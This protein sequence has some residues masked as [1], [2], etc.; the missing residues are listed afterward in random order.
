MVA[1]ATIGFSFAI[2]GSGCSKGFQ[3]DPYSSESDAVKHRIA[4]TKDVQVPVGKADPSGSLRIDSD[5]NMEFS[6]GLPGTWHIGGRILTQVDGHDPV[7]G[8]D[9]EISIDNIADF[10]FANFDA[11]TGTL[12]W[13]PKPGFV[14]DHFTRNVHFDISLVT[15]FAPIRKT[16]KSLLAV[17]T[18]S[19]VTPSVISIEDLDTNPLHEGEK[20]VFQ[21]V[22]R[23]PHA[24]DKTDLRPRLTIVASTPSIASAAGYISLQNGMGTANPIRDP[25]DATQWIFSLVIDL[26]S[27]D[28][29]SDKITL[30]FGII[31]TSRFGEAS[32]MKTSTATVITSLNAPL[33]SWDETTP[34]DVVAGKENTVNVSVFDPKSAGNLTV[35]FNTR[36]DIMLGTSATCSCNSAP[37]VGGVNTQLCTIRWSVPPTPL[38]TQYSVEIQAINQSKYDAQQVITK[39]TRSLRVVQP[40]VPP[41]P[42]VVPVGQQTVTTSSLSTSRTPNKGTN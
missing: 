11:P 24:D 9:Y 30:G 32:Q 1:V 28:V 12:T 37:P 18:R 14:Q 23:D 6:E 40:G 25:S 15:K 33:I 34:I 8:Q 3:Q 27:K 21:V 19:E 29:T 22:V 35:T 39:F 5:D 26:R 7:I 36:C 31:A 17:V 16:T 38:Q 42:F 10:P 13:T 41:T 4:P 2:V 20:R